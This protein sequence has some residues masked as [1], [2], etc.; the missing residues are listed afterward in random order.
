MKFYKNIN[1]QPQRITSTVSAVIT[2]AQLHLETIVYLQVFLNCLAG[3]F[4]LVLNFTSLTTS[5]FWQ[6]D[7]PRPRSL[8]AGGDLKGQHNRDALEGLRF[9]MLRRHGSRAP[10]KRSGK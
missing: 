4:T 2:R 9:Q 1:L 7:L 3:P 5:S 8:Q 6:S 10:L